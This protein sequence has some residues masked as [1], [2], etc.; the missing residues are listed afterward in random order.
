MPGKLNFHIRLL[1]TMLIF[2]SASVRL[3]AQSP[4]E[5]IEFDQRVFNFGSIAEK[6]GK[7]THRFK[8]KN[9][10][11]TPVTITNIN[12]GCGCL[13]QRSPEKPIPPGSTGEIAIT[14]DPAYKS[15]FFSKEIVVLSEAGSRYNRIWVE[16]TIQPK[17]RPVEDEYP[18]AFGSGL[19]LRLKVMAFGYL[20]GG[21]SR[22]MKL[23]IAN[24]SG[25]AM[26][27][28]FEASGAITG[29]QFAQPGTLAKGQRSEIEFSF[30]MPEFSTK[31]IHYELYPVVNGRRLNE[32]I[33]VK[34]LNDAN[35]AK[36]PTNSSR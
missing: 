35:S 2:S 4:S 36:P 11:K 25:R 9:K 33:I 34:V 20:R 1:M 10:G 30:R 22:K 23:H 8:F 32:P 18:Y 3:C 12:T 15:G 31:D 16:G 13:V 29:L 7:V 28:R 24:E 6:D 14:F 27:L 17:A 21:E 26:N 5:S 19:Y